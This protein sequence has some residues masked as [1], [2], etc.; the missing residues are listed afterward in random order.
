MA[1]FA[2]F[3]AGIASGFLFGWLACKRSHRKWMQIACGGLEDTLREAREQLIAA[4]MR[5]PEV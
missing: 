1:N 5:R 4:R 3:T 2:I